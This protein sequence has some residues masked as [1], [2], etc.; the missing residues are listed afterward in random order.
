MVLKIFWASLSLCVC[1]CVRVL[2]EEFQSSYKQGWESTIYKAVLIP[3]TVTNSYKIGV[4]MLRPRMELLDH[5][6]KKHLSVLHYWRK[7]RKKLLTIG[8]YYELQ[9]LSKY[10]LPVITLVKAPTK[11]PASPRFTTWVTENFAGSLIF[12]VPL[13][14][15]EYSF[16]GIWC[17]KFS[18]DLWAKMS[19]FHREAVFENTDKRWKH[20]SRKRRVQHQLVNHLLF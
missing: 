5:N 7:I 19:V 2:N 18:S 12:W 8:S 3:R 1:V 15:L 14:V 20:K 4:Y 17:F 10:L 11:N 16:H 13:K 9:C 6:S